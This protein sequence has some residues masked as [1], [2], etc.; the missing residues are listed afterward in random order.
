MNDPRVRASVRSFALCSSR[1]RL[2]ARVDSLHNV[3]RRLRRSRPSFVR[4]FARM[5]RA[6]ASSSS[7]SSSFD[8]SSRDGMRASSRGGGSTARRFASRVDGR[9]TSL[10]HA[11]TQTTRGAFASSSSSSSS[12]A[13]VAD[14]RG[15]RAVSRCAVRRVDAG[16]EEPKIILAR[17]R[18]STQTTTTTTRTTTKTTDAHRKTDHR[19]RAVSLFETP[20]ATTA[21]TTTIRTTA[22]RRDVCSRSRSRARETRR[23]DDDDDVVDATKITRT[24]TTVDHRATTETTAED[25][26]RHRH[27]HGH[28]RR[29]DASAAAAAAAAAAARAR[30]PPTPDATTTD[31]KAALR[32]ER[33][34]LRSAYELVVA[35]RDDARAI[36]ERARNAERDAARRLEASRLRHDAR[37]RHLRRAIDV[38]EHLRRGRASSGDVD[39]FLAAC[40]RDF[41]ASDD[42]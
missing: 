6:Q 41:A 32:E 4:S 5:T 3:P 39:D 20:V 2:F 28:R 38:I 33:D 9:H 16:R 30:P 40:R 23:A 25:A 22:T 35:E 26:G 29:R 1:V 27:R 15:R 42:A 34:A 13:L 7:S 21:T 31:A 10:G 14:A 24:E 11:T 8:P 17:R 36:R 12:S 18:G 37:A 19:A